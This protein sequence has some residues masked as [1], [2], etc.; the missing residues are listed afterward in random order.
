MVLESSGDC[1]DRYEDTSE[2]PLG[3]GTFATIGVDLY[4]TLI[5]GTSELVRGTC[6][7]GVRDPGD[8]PGDGRAAGRLVELDERGCPRALSRQD[9]SIEELTGAESLLDRARHIICPSKNNTGPLGAGRGS[10]V[11]RMTESY[12][13][14]KAHQA[15]HSN[16]AFGSK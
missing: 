9:G 5:Q 7:D 4:C 13:T 10:A 15:P 3:S 8:D 14:T 11:P 6:P 12:P 16:M 1:T 2:P